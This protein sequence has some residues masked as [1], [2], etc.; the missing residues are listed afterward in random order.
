MRSDPPTRDQLEAKNEGDHETTFQQAFGE[1]SAKLTNAIAENSSIQ[2]LPLDP[3]APLTTHLWH[4][5][6]LWG[7]ELYDQRFSLPDSQKIA[8][9][10]QI[11]IK[12]FIAQHPT[13]SKVG[14]IIQRGEALAEEISQYAW[15]GILGG[16]ALA[17]FGVA[18]LAVAVASIATGAGVVLLPFGMALAKFNIEALV[19]A[20]VYFA[21][22]VYSS[23]AKVSDKEIIEIME[24]SKDTRLTRNQRIKE[25]IGLALYAIPF[26][27]AVSAVLGWLVSM[28]AGIKF[29]NVSSGIACAFGKTGSTATVA[30]AAGNTA[31]WAAISGMSFTAMCGIDAVVQGG[32]LAKKGCQDRNLHHF[33]L[34]FFKAAQPRPSTSVVPVVSGPSFHAT[35]TGRVS[36]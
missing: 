27:A 28:K 18:L 33:S 24:L 11:Y 25:N 8:L 15:G 10:E 2:N 21:A 31:T 36:G 14:E 6:W 32:L 5:L 3:K 7:N 19:L 12:L 4:H 17:F 9:A 16:I 22:R 29:M 30:T 1:L 34:K 23:A 35:K 20:G 26:A 13:A